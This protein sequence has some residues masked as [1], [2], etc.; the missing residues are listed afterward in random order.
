MQ[1]G[2]KNEIHKKVGKG[3]GV[4][5]C[6]EVSI[7]EEKHL[8]VRACFTHGHRKAKVGTAGTR[9]LR[10]Y[11]LRP[12]LDRQDNTNCCKSS[13]VWLQLG[14]LPGPENVWIRLVKVHGGGLKEESKW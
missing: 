14:Q 11:L 8:H 5:Y 4:I 2:Y 1:K 10:R 12:R 7:T 13:V 6:P 9:A 3:I